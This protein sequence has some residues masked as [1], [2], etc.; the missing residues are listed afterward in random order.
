VYT[1]GFN[2]G[3]IYDMGSQSDGQEF[4]LRTMTT[5]D[6]WRVQRW[7]YPT[8]DFD[9]VYPTENR[10]VHFAQVYENNF[11]VLYA[12]GV[13]IGTQAVALDT[14]N[15]N[16]VIGR[17]GASTSFAGIID[18]LRVYNKALTQEEVKETMRGD[19]LLA[20]DPMP[21]SGSTPNVKDAQ[22]VSWSP[23]E[24]ASQHDV[25]FGTDEDAVKNGDASDT[26]GT[27]RGRQGGTSYTAPEGVE[28]GTGPYYWRIDE[29]N[30][31]A[32]LSKGRVWNFTVADF[33]G[34]D[35]MESYDVDNA[36]WA[37]WH[38][39][40][41]YVDDQGVT[42]PGNG[43]GSEVGDP[44]TGSYTEET[45]RHSGSQ[46]MPYWYNNSGLTGKLNYSEAKLT[47]TAPRDWTQENVRALSVWFQGRPGSVG[48]FVESPPG[49]YTMTAT[50]G[51]IWYAA[52]EFHYAYKMLSGVATIMARVESVGNTD[53][54]AK[55]GVMIRETLEPGSK[56]AAVYITPGN[57]CRFQARI[58]TDVDATSDTPVVT[59]EQTAIT[60]PYWV[61]LER[62]V[63]GNFTGFYSSNGATWQPMSW[64]PQSI[65]MNSNVYVGLALTA[66]NAAATCQA[67]LSNV[68]I[69]G[70]VSGAWT[71]QDIG[72]E[73]NA[74]E[75]MYVAVANSTGTPAVVYHD[76]PA[77]AQIDTWTEWNID[78]K[79]F[80][81]KGINL[82]DVDSI[83]LGFGDRN[84][85]QVGGSGKMYFDDIRLYRPRCVPDE[86]TLS[87]ADLNS[88]CVVDY[89]DLEIIVGDWLAG[90]P[91]LAGDL[92]VDDTVDFNDYAV[93]ADQ[94]LD[95][96]I[97]P[98]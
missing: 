4:C 71:N 69:T 52:D 35:N 83:A 21:T 74:A 57:G 60:A 37:N 39:G 92:N 85:P 66:H 42:H 20:W 10:W 54:W 64:N 3:G 34:I 84:N 90:D 27:Y 38:D 63:A 33:I 2:N 16:F 62:D 86:L 53:P 19:P 76:D 93:L 29:Y 9:V 48:S 78:L 73:S 45:I 68:T 12:N 91:G 77:A 70:N 59:P 31:D 67:V 95:E 43:T 47:L 79:D 18:D 30:T 1:T 75:P 13:S 72:I 55:A 25:Y 40:L 36:I 6:N 82:T 88:D 17:Y 61:R 56:F 28:W 41:G 87:R 23:G 7:G 8:Y 96:Q 80:Q 89:R 65:Q 14:A 98:E 5:V 11:T 46:S 49:T 26:T 58:D 50:G 22:T 15:A 51:D 81:D 24:K 97:W 32:T 94:W 44:S